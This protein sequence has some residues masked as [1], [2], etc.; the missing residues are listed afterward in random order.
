MALAKANEKIQAKVKK[1]T[2]E[3]IKILCEIEN[4]SESNM[5]EYMINSYIEN[6]EKEHGVIISGGGGRLRK[7][8]DYFTLCSFKYCMMFSGT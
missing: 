8:V 2:R 3:K 6:Y 5:V 4:R 1:E 7:A